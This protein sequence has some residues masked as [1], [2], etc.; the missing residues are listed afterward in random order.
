MN[1]TRD[2]LQSPNPHL[3][4]IGGIMYKELFLC[5]YLPR[6]DIMKAISSHFSELE[7]EIDTALSVLEALITEEGRLEVLREFQEDLNVIFFYEDTNL[8]HLF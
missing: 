6:S 4:E 1:L 7:S 5:P 8:I 2:L 3:N